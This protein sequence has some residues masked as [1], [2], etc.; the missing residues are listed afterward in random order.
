MTRRALDD[1]RGWPRRGL[2]DLRSLVATNPVLTL[3]V[4]AIGFALL[5]AGPPPAAFGSI[6]VLPGAALMVCA[7]AYCTHRRW[8]T[9]TAVTAAAG[10]VLAFTVDWQERQPA[11]LAGI[12]RDG[13]AL[14]AALFVGWGLRV[15]GERFRWLEGRA[16]G[17]AMDRQEAVRQAVSEERRCLAQELH[18]MIGCSWTLIAL[19]VS[20]ARRIDRQ[21]PEWVHRL[22]ERVETVAQS[23]L[24]EAREVEG[25]LWRGAGE[26]CHTRYLS[27]L[28]TLATMAEGTGC[29]V[30]LRISGRARA[31]PRALEHSAFRIVQEGL[32]NALRHAGASTAEIG[33]EYSDDRLR[34]SV[35]DNGRGRIEKRTGGTGLAGMRER[36]SAL[37]GR[38]EVDD[39]PG[40]GC[41][42]TAVLPTGCQP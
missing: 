4:A 42:I 33:V 39:R 34:V 9:A 18:D 22:L 30:T 14:G 12:S 5:L 38:L 31:M 35:A 13:L 26:T 36:A 23:A 8:A 41:C 25:A 17:S 7:A 15:H 2:G 24:A 3:G 37:G 28:A 10:A 40:L 19:Q 16:A 20:A 1:R 6:S 27:Q 29:R 32:T 11:T 21:S